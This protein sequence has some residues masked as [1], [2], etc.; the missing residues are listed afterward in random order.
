MTFNE[1]AGAVVETFAKQ[2]ED[3]CWGC[4]HIHYKGADELLR[5]LVTVAI[6]EAVAE[7]REDC[8][9]IAESVGQSEE[10]SLMVWGIIADCIRNL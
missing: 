7:M 9:L 2:A 4:D 10:P 6:A 5:E 1:R 8:A 3:W